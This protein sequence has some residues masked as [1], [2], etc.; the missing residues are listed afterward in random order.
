MPDTDSISVRSVRSWFTKFES[1]AETR[2][3][4]RFVVNRSD[5]RSGD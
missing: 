3:G 1:K 4:G 5:G 2:G